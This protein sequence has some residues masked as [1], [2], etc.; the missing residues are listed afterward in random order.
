MWMCA[1]C[2][3]KMKIKINEEDNNRNITIHTNGLLIQVYEFILFYSLC[4]SL[5]LFLFFFSLF[6]VPPVL[7]V[8]NPPHS[9]RTVHTELLTLKFVFYVNFW[10]DQ[11]F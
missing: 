1:Y 11:R 7:F 6:F 9:T 4:I 10:W 2:I 5:F 3:I 8:D